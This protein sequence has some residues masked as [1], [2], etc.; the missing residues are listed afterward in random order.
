MYFVHSGV[1]YESLPEAVPYPAMP[2]IK[3]NKEGVAKLLHVLKLNPSK[4]SRPDLIPARVLKL[5]A[6]EIAPFLLGQFQGIGV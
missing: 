3:V 6:N 4:A 2:D 5:F 1:Q